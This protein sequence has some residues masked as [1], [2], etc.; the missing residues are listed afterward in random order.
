VGAGTRNRA[1]QPI[2][3]RREQTGVLGCD[4][5]FSY[6]ATVTNGDGPVTRNVLDVTSNDNLAYSARVNWDLKGHIGYDEGALRQHSCEWLLAIGA[7]GFAYSDILNDKAHTKL[8]DRWS[9]G[10]DLAA[11]Y[12]GWSLTS[13][14]NFATADSS[15]VGFE[16]DAWSWLIQ[17]GFL[18]PDTA[19]EFA[20]RYSAYSID[21]SGGGDNAGASEFGFAVNYYIDGHA[22][23]LTLDVAFIDG[24]YEDFNDML[25]VYAA[26][27]PTGNGNALLIRFQ[28]Q[29]AL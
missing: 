25:D 4:G 15:D 13:A 29:L 6:L 16:F 17:I 8:A 1:P 10:L 2:G 19:W 27:E 7:W 12:G 14:I 28:W 9:Y 20:A 23:K 3:Q 11:G 22:D 5:E 26:Y 21:P 24:S 18:I